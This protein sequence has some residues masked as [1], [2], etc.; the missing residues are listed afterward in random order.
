MS[1]GVIAGQ[2]A[3]AAALLHAGP[4][5]A[6]ILARI[7]G[8]AGDAARAEAARLGAM[9]RP[10]RARALAARVAEL[11]SPVPIGLP[12]V[13]RDWIDAALVGEG[14]RVRDI[15][16]GA[17]EVAPP[18]R[19]WIE[20]RIY[21]GVVAIPLPSGGA[22]LTPETLPHR[23]PAAIEAFL[24]RAGA[25]TLAL[26]IGIEARPVI[27]QVAARLGASGPELVECVA[28][29]AGRPEEQARLGSR[30][31]AARR[32]AG[33][34]VGDDPLALLA[35]GART[36]APFLGG[37]LARQVAQRLPRRSGLRML[38]EVAAFAADPDGPTWDALVLA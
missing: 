30:R 38:T 8:V 9:D 16:R 25:L 22:A 5:V 37:S 13:H 2:A 33:I 23:A 7:G 32:V 4:R 35:V 18:V 31:A 1:D 26:A 10:A 14:S 36:A 21:G 15:I 11:R 19:V 24:R 20:R 12:L 3:A 6:A 28:A 29:L 34:A 17:A 27:A